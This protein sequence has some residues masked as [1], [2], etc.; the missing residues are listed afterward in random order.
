MTAANI[1][2]ARNEL[3]K[4]ER[5]LGEMRKALDAAVAREPVVKRPEFG[6]FRLG[7]RSMERLAGVHPDLMAVVQYAI[8]VTPVDFGIPRTGGVRTMEQ[9]REL[10]A[11]G[12]SKTLNSR[13]LT[14]HAVDIYAIA[15]GKASWD[16][17]L[18]REVHR[19]FEEAWAALSVPLRWGGDF[20]DFQDL[21]HHE[22]PR[23]LYGDS[24]ESLSERARAF[25]E[26]IER[27]S[28]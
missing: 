25:L 1:I 7:A 27:E 21:V 11:T 13:H 14:G 12:K 15:G 9:Q 16:H 10:L 2:H 19:A 26:E 24:M 28:T 3:A 20:T 4:A 6:D 17:D 22:L 23:A 5:A 8:R 18:I